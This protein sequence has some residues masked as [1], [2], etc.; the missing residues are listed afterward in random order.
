MGED[1]WLKPL[2]LQNG[3]LR[4]DDVA[5]LLGGAFVLRTFPDS[6]R[7][8]F[9]VDM[10]KATNVP[11]LVRQRLVYYILNRGVNR[12][13][14]ENGLDVVIVIN[15]IGMKVSPENG[16]TLELAHSTSS[17]KLNK[18]VLVRDPTD[19]R[20]TLAHLFE[21]MVL[22]MVERFWGGGKI[23]TIAAKTAEGTMK[24][25]SAHGYPSCTIPVNLG[26]DWTY[27][28]CMREWLWR[29]LQI[30]NAEDSAP[31]TAPAAPVEQGLAVSPETYAVAPRAAFAD[32]GGVPPP[33]KIRKMQQ[34]QSTFSAAPPRP[35]IS[36]SW[37]QSNVG[38]TAKAASERVDA[39]PKF[40]MVLETDLIRRACA[41]L[42]VELP[43]NEVQA[44]R[45]RNALYSR[46]SYYK[47][48][49]KRSIME[50]EVKELQRQQDALRGEQKRLET[51]LQQARNLVLTLD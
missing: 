1:Y 32:G 41:D 42:D 17:F 10:S 45:E 36:D 27:S 39:S 3:A 18:V 25:L 2:R 29:R 14:H 46:R 12:F 8:V 33:A 9:I 5:L 30:E 40:P 20:P 48:K 24:G 51:L 38:V 7:Q 13:T 34:L 50:G 21:K 6:Q 49:R 44:M 22:R 43:S 28:E 4:P 35:A 15:G 31:P 26:G 23:F 11:F 19:S 16:R 47:R 37:P